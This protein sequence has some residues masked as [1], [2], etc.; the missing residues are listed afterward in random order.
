MDYKLSKFN[1]IFP[2]EDGIIIYNSLSGGVLKLNSKYE[3]QYY[4]IKSPKH[5]MV[6]NELI[7]NLL[8]ANMIVD[9]KL[10]EVSLLRTINLISRYKDSS[11]SLTIA[12]TLECNFACP[13][14][15]EKG[16]RYNRMNKEVQNALVEF[17]KVKL[18]NKS[19][20]GICWYGGEPL[21][22]IDIIESI[23]KEIRN[24]VP[25]YHASMVSN[26]FLLNRAM[27]QR[28]V[29]AGIEYIQV[30]L[31]GPKEIHDARR[32]LLN[33]E[34]S[35]NTILENIQNV[36]D[37]VKI[38][39]RVN[40]DKENMAGVAQLLDAL[41]DYH[42]TG[43][44]KLYLAP[45]DNINQTCDESCCFTG[46]EFAKEQI[47]FYR[48]YCNREYLGKVIPESALQSCGAVA[49]SSYLIDPLGDL[50]KCWDDIGNLKEKVGDIF[51][52]TESGRIDPKLLQWLQYD[53]IDCDECKN[54]PV[55][56]VCMGGCANYYFKTG[57]HKCHPIKYNLEEVVKIKRD[58]KDRV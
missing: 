47:L 57:K 25:E 24:L 31:D 45:V 5:E 12:P 1:T 16:R 39:I 23:T 10:D 20:L 6:E 50:Y 21:M 8:R 17:V 35:F 46:S 38:K 48:E 27:A 28:V 13:Y 40:V 33:G 22:A 36:C 34:G 15:Y 14:C 44:V 7:D 43:K 18:R 11:L 26:G 41:D 54:C 42:L 52:G 49:V 32:K 9:F 56:P 51:T 30:T 2:Q 58:L 4:A 3:K 19:A 29:N 55:L 37:L 53:A